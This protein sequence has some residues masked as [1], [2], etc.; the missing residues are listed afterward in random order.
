VRVNYNRD[1]VA[2]ATCQIE[3][4]VE[5]MHEHKLTHEQKQQL[6]DGLPVID[7]GPKKEEW[8]LPIKFT[9]KQGD[10]KIGEDFK[11]PRII[12]FYLSQQDQF[13]DERRHEMHAR[14]KF[15]VKSKD[16][17]DKE[18]GTNQVYQ[19]TFKPDFIKKLMV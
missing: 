9:I 15:N 1:L 4:P 7:A 12:D 8:G 14:V 2:A 18:F 3:I 10:V 17:Y 5:I 11:K 16:N 19:F 6:E 13:P